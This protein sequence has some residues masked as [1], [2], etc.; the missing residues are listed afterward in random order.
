MPKVFPLSRRANE[1]GGKMNE[2]ITKIREAICSDCGVRE[3]ELHKENCDMERCP[4]C[5]GQLLLCDCNFQGT[6]NDGKFLLIEGKPFKRE[7]YILAPNICL[8]CG[9]VNPE[10]F[11]VSKE[12]WKEVCGIT[13]EFDSILCKSCFEFIKKLRG[14]I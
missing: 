11:M 4:K 9:E 7:P 5:K 6:S 13:F 3:G 2:T 1:Q 12:E 8:K 14:L 10:L